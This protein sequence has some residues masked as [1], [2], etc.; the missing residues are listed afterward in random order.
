MQRI[1]WVN[2]LQECSLRLKRI[3]K[4]L[5]STLNKTEPIPG[6][7]A[8]GDRLEKV[9]L[10]AEKAI[11]DTFRKHS[12]SFTLISEESGT[13]AFG[14]RADKCFVTTDP[15][16]GSTNLEHHIPFYATSIAVSTEPFLE[17]VHSSLVADLFHGVTYTA[18][19]GHGSLRDDQRIVPSR[20]ASLE[21][22]VLGMDMNSYKIKS[23][24]P[25]LNEVIVR[26]KHI[27][28]LGANA[29]ELCYV[30][31]GTTDAFIDI[32]GKLRPTDMAGAW[33]IIREAGARITTPEG[34]PLK[35]RLDPGEKVE[36]VASGNS[37]IHRI[38]LDLIR[39][40]KE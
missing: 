1:V 18:E 39:T 23:L 19:K 40:R 29:L 20:N 16:D 33:L 13:Q 4:P 24:I 6:F 35:V 15:I 37:E 32:R 31:D 25:R 26:T 7:G 8:G 36:F 30:A 21:E 5:L 3:I 27:R 12:V 28:H 10:V 2:I 14:N 22:A 17:T 11:V 9:D 38:L 34:K